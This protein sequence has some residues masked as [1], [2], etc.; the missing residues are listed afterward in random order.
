MSPVASPVYLVELFDLES[1]GLDGA[2]VSA[3]LGLSLQ[4]VYWHLLMYDDK[5]IVKV[6]E[7]KQQALEGIAFLRAD[8]SILATIT[9]YHLER[10]QEDASEHVKAVHAVAQL[11]GASRLE[12]ALTRL[13]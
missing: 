6:N 1:G 5:V 9:V 12:E 10:E 7:D 2:D 3:N 4:A 8:D 13:F 11:E